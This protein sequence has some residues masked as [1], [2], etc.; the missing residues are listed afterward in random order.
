MGKYTDATQAASDGPARWR[1]RLTCLTCQPRSP[2]LTDRLRQPEHPLG[3]L[4]WSCRPNGHYA[5]FGSVVIEAPRRLD[6]D[7]AGRREQVTSAFT[8]QAATRP[9]TARLAEPLSQSPTEQTFE[10]SLR[11]FID[12]FAANATGPVTGPRDH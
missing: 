9:L 6:P 2:K 5:T 7:P 10:T 12:G 4:G 11:W 8:E 3:R 1:A